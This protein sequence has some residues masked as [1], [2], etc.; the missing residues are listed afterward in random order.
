MPCPYTLSARYLAVRILLVCTAM[1]SASGA[2]GDDSDGNHFSPDV[3]ALY[4]GVSQVSP[5][6]GTDVLFLD[7][8]ETVVFDAQGRVIRSRYFLYKILTQ[9]GADAWGDISSSWEPWHQQQ[10]ILRARVITPDSVVHALDPKTITDAPAKETEDKVFSDRRVLRA[11]LP[12]IAPGSLVE[13]E[14]GSTESAPFVGAGAV[15]RFYFGASVP[16]QHTRIILD[17]PAALPLRYEIQLLPDLK[18][19]RR[20][21]EG[22]IR[23]T[24][25]YGL[26]DALEDAEPGLPS[27][28]PLYPSITFS[29][30]DS[31][32]TVADEYSK[33]VDKQISSA[34]L[35][36]LVAKLT[37]GSASREAKAS[38]ILA[39][40]DRE[41]RYTGV[42]FGE[43][44][45]VPHPPPKLSI[46]STATAK[47]KQLCWWPCCGLQIYPRT[48]LFSTRAAGKTLLPTFPAWVFSITPSFMLPARPTSGSMPQTNMPGWA[49]FLT[50]TRG[51]SR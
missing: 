47:T 5:P 24:F 33:I 29:T 7:D 45:M 37:Q 20:E 28:L 16:V 50:L 1:I 22:R 23:L 43:S 10:P 32:H 2:R 4:Q 8:E 44:A 21:T 31:W 51:V 27:D 34:D 46:T 41:V 11:P 12:A 18:P 40:L 42:E 15:E 14:L 3:A 9:K 35:K 13:Q 6:P 26:A 39:F 36:S 49:S 48:S 17:A 30:G 19:Q 38:A 25:D